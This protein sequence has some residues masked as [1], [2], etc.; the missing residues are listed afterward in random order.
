M[1]PNWWRKHFLVPSSSCP[2]LCSTTW[3][4]SCISR[5]GGEGRKPR[6]VA[7]FS[8][9]FWFFFFEGSSVVSRCL[10][11]EKRRGLHCCSSYFI[12]LGHCWFPCSIAV[13]WSV[14]KQQSNRLLFQI[15]ANAVRA[16][17][18]D[19]LLVSMATIPT[20]IRYGTDVD[21][22]CNVIPSQLSCK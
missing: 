8:I 14:F 7:S 13:M 18:P 15:R 2:D 1:A 9:D 5:C 20:F 16:M 4:N 12:P 17:L 6:T 11:R 10:W 3:A 21:R 22:T 19:I